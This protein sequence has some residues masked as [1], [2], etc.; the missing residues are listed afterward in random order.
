M[1]FRLTS[2]AFAN[3]RRI[4]DLHTCD[5]QDT[6]PPLAWSDVPDG[7]RSL[8]LIVTD[9]DAPVGT[10]YHWAVF[11]IPPESTGLAP[12]YPSEARQEGCRQAIN[13]FRRVGY[14]GP[15]PPRGHGQHHYRFRL[16]ALNVRHLDL[17][18]GADCRDVE[19]AA[20]AHLLIDVSLTGL[21]SR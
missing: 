16:M 19:A 6:S 12:A 4:P 3:A 9:P 20:E 5:G 2:T 14:G 13:D 1:A 11:D 15:C 8:A 18:E 10:W 21:Y 17:P 7:A